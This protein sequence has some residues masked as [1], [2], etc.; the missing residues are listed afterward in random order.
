M[1]QDKTLKKPFGFGCFEARLFLG[2][3]KQ[4]KRW[5]FCAFYEN[6]LFQTD[7]LN[8][9]FFTKMLQKPNV[10]RRIFMVEVKTTRDSR[11]RRLH[12]IATTLKR[13]LHFDVFRLKFKSVF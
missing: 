6:R 5:V 11:Q 7:V 2:A 10:L 8:D 12:K 9:V 4:S 1:P 13:E 3:Q